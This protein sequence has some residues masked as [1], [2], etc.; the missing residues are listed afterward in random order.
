M[1]ETHPTGILISMKEFNKTDFCP[2]GSGKKYDE[3]CGAIISG[4]KKAETAEELMRSRY[5]AYV[6]HEIDYIVRTCTVDEQNAIDV[7]ETRKWSEE[8][9][10]QGL[11]I[12]KTDKGGP[13]DSEGVVDFSATYSRKGLRDVHLE[14]AFFKKVNGEWLYESGELIP[15]TVVRQGAK[16]GRNDPCPCGSGKKYKHCCGR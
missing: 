9:E 12:I 8:S 13:Q 4:A 16:I 7:E 10:W 15:T 14:R 1:K 6:A 5:S 11:K 3:C 2:C